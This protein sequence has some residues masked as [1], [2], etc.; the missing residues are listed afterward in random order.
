MPLE[1]EL[2]LSCQPTFQR[3]LRFDGHFWNPADR[4]SMLFRAPFN[5]LK[6]TTLTTYT[7]QVP[8]RFYANGLALRLRRGYTSNQLLRHSVI[9]R[10]AGQEKSSIVCAAL[11]ALTDPNM[12]IMRH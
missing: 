12:E 1:P 4:H 9:S 5:Q 10:W 7:M 3:I 8:R 2:I 6:R 11:H